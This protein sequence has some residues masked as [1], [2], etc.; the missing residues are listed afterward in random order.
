MSPSDENA[1]ADGRE[2]RGGAGPTGDAVRD[3]GPGVGS[4][5]GPDALVVEGLSFRYGSYL[6]LDDVSLAVPQGRF[7]CLL[8]ANG[9][10]KTTLFSILTG[11]FAARGGRVRVLG[12]DLVRETGAAL[13]SLGVVFQ[14]P[15]LDMDL[16]VVQN[17][18]YFAD[19]Q[20]L[21]REEAA[22]RIDEALGR[23]ALADLERRRAG[24]L[25]GGQRRR[26]ELARALLHRP[27]LVLL[28]EPTVGL[29]ARS[30][31]DFVAHVRALAADEGVG[32]L[33][34]THL[35]DEVRGS[36]RVCVLA[37]GKLVASGELPDLLAEHGV[38]DVGALGERLAVARPG[39]PPFGAAAEGAA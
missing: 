17:L 6:A 30:R 11:L 31:T 1:G 13:G 19:L 25:S 14:R 39:P 18:R 8:G 35:M 4:G 32:I 12:H 27:A 16:T 23:H 36:D 28:D 33:W 34:A 26:V 22:R 29:D 2:A 38:A 10:G 20:G 5:V 7:A 21:P 24:T 9:A 37:A 15:T 3:A